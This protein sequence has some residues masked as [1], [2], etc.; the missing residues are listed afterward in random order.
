MSEEFAWLQ[1]YLLLG[2]VLFALGLTGFL[3]RRNLIVMFLCAEMMLQGVSLSLVAWGRFHGN[4]AGQSLVVFVITVAA[5]EAGIALALV[6]MLCR[7]TGNLDVTSWQTLREDGTRPFVD[8]EVPEEAAVEEPWPSLT[9]AGV[10]PAADPTEE[11]YRS[12]V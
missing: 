1:N 6:L 4:W 5:C 10:E 11:W 3:V 2:T 7:R 9:P 8:N 12:H